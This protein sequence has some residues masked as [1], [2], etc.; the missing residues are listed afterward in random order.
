MKLTKLQIAIVVTVAVALALTLSLTL[1]LLPN[2]IPNPE[3]FNCPEWSE[4][5]EWSDYEDINPIVILDDQDFNNYSFIGTGTENDP[6]IIEGYRI[7]SDESACISIRDTT[8]HFIIRN[9]SLGF[10]NESSNHEG[11][12]ISDIASNTAKISNN[13][14][15]NVKGGVVVYWSE[16]VLVEYNVFRYM[17]PRLQI[18]WDY[19][20]DG[21][22][23]VVLR[24]CL[25]C[26]VNRNMFY[27]VE[28]I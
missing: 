1:T 2:H 20:V 9:C 13:R 11:I 14:I 16:G 23:A 8:K 6:Y 18:D 19:F 21:G 17:L 4:Y 24:S 3:C 15:Q 7:I 28:N 26:T 25:N 27:G 22:A 5:P 10:H 12:Y